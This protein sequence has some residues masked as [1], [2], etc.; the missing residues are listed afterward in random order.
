MTIDTTTR[1]VLDCVSA[2][3]DA[4]DRPVCRHYATTGRPM[5]AF[6]CECEPGV[7]GNLIAQVEQIYD[8]DQNLNQIERVQNCRQGTKAVDITM[9]LTRCY[10]TIDETGELDIDDVDA[11]T[12]GLHDDMDILR[13][14]FA[15]CTD[16]RLKV[17]R[18]A[19]DSDPEAG[20]SMIAG[21]ITVE[22]V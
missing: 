3:F 9:W 14:A 22:L 11:T 10:P 13:Q 20:C 7:T 1:G 5:V 16:F 2:A 19:I 21:Q 12:T 4:A 8:T 18:I 15:C 17:R 6:C